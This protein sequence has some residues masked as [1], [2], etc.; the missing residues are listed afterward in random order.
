MAYLCLGVNIVLSVAKGVAGVGWGSSS[1]LVDAVHSASDTISD[2]ATIL[3]LYK[4]KQKP[5]ARY[6]LGYGR[7]ET[8]GS[9]FISCMLLSGSVSIGIHALVQMLERLAPVFPW[10]EQVR[11]LV[12]QIP[13]PSAHGHAHE[14][15]PALTEPRAI[16]FVIMNLI[17]KEMLYRAMRRTARQTRST[18]L[19]A[20]AQHQRSESS[21][22]IMSLLALSGSWAGYSWLDPLGGMARAIHNGADAWHLLVRSLEHLCNR[23]ADTDVL[24]TMEKVLAAGAAQSKESQTRPAFTWSDLAVVPNGPFLVV[25]VTLYFERHVALQDAAATED[26]VGERIRAQY[27]ELSIRAP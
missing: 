14:H 11:V 16:L 18:M 13:D 24:Q 1:L 17:I 10:L 9:F 22:S 25:F 8:L 19:E 27:P 15:G 3:C 5:T 2:L 20:S 4:A 12:Y 7:M 21:A 26:W 6:P 23:S